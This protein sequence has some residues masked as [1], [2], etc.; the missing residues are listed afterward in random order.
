M[1][2][3]S[4]GNDKNTIKV[5]DLGYYVIVKLFE[6]GSLLNNG[7]QICIDNLFTSLKLAKHLYTKL[8]ALTGMVRFNRKGIPKELLSKFG[9]GKTK[10]ERKD[11]MLTVGFRG[12]NLRR[13]KS[14]CYLL[15]KR[16]EKLQKP[17]DEGPSKL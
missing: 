12:K 5:T 7:Y 2:R 4:K 15:T 8:T 16:L 3:E 10:Y 11:H 9:F 6:M 17:K 14:L 1:Y 13:N